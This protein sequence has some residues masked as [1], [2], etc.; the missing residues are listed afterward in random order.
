MD[1]D[2]AVN[3]WHVSGGIYRMGRREWLTEGG[4]KQAFDDGVRTVVDLRNVGEGRRRD[5]DPVVPAAALTGIDVVYAPTEEPDD[6]RF[7][8]LTGP[9]LNDPAHY[10]GNARLFPEKLVGVFRALASA[11][12]KGDVLLHCAAGRD[13]SG[14]VAAMVQDLAGDSDEAIAE[15][16]RRAA[17][18]INERYRTHGPPHSRERYLEDPELG[19]LLE[20]RGLAVVAFVRNLGTR[21]YLLA[22]GLSPAEL[23]AVLVICRPSVDTMGPV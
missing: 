8:A 10:A 17:R 11:A 7:T 18:G 21:S 5:T 14:M 23:D 12:P 4:W 6:P 22:N 9:Y 19:P 3:A 15:G 2:G 16:Y 1:W 20:R 13:R